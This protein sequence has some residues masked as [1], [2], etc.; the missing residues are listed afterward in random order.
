MARTTISG[1]ELRDASITNDDIAAAAAIATTKLAD[2]AAF[3]KSSGAVAMAADFNF[4]GFK[5]TNLGTPTLST[6]AAT[7]A[8][9]DAQGGGSPGG[10]DTN[11]QFNSASAFAGDANLTWNTTTD[12]LTVK[13]AVNKQALFYGAFGA[14]ASDNSGQIQIGNNASWY[15]KIGLEGVSNGAAFY[16][17][18]L[19]DTGPQHIFRGR[20]S[21][22][23]VTILTLTGNRYVGIAEATAPGAVLDSKSST[24]CQAWFRGWSTVGGAADQHG[25]IRFGNANNCAI[26]YDGTGN[27]MYLD[28]RHSDATTYI[29]FRLR[30]GGTP[31]TALKLNG[32]KSV[33]VGDAALATTA[34]DGFLYFTSCAGLPTGIP[35]SETGRT[36]IVWDSTNSK[37]Y[38]YQGGWTQI[39]G[40]SWTSISAG[41]ASTVST[42]TNADTS[43]VYKV[44]QTTAGRVSW[45]FTEQA[46]SVSTSTPVLLQVDTISASTAIPLLVKSR[47][48]EVFRVSATATQILG[49]NGSAANPTY[50]FLSNTNL[51][52]WNNS[53]TLSITA[54]GQTKVEIDNSQFKLTNVPIAISYSGSGSAPDIRDSGGQEGIFF[55]ASAVGISVGG[56]ENSRFAASVFQPSKGSADADSYQLNFRKSRGSVASPTVITTGD[57][58]ALISGFGYV[59]ATNAYVE[60]ANIVFESFGAVSDSSTGLSGLIAFQVREAGGA[61][62]KA[63]QVRGQGSR[64]LSGSAGVPSISDI[65][66]ENSGLF[67]PAAGVLGFTSNLVEAGRLS[68]SQNWIIGAGE[69][70]AVLTS[71]TLRGPNASGTDIAA[72]SLT[73]QNALGTGTGTLGK[74]ILK[75]AAAGTGTGTAQHTAVERL[76]LN[77]SVSLTSGAAAT[78]VTPTASTTKTSGGFVVYHVEATD[79]VDTISASG[80]VAYGIVN[81]AAAYT[82]VTSVIGTEAQAKSDVTDTIVNTFAFSSNALQI[83]STITGMTPTTF[84]VTYMVVSN[85]QEAIVLP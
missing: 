48:S 31:V 27:A 83:T 69:A 23:I 63:L 12:L 77:G 5:G 72:A 74:L 51:G 43:I 29:Y 19:N 15:L 65:T 39:G 44:S 28:N 60:A 11:I 66:S 26:H 32:A 1:S 36:P 24:A 62:I 9:V 78:I 59:G 37:F 53:G 13:S 84:R 73:I 21:G 30:V 41:A 68:S 18:G 71:Q 75:A 55:G 61:L 64:F 35:T 3:L 14:A 16:D 10:V 76:V 46:A 82:A 81:K 4:G 38:A 50:A 45:Q 79:G 52:I 70:S 8:Y 22:S 33:I 67:W 54:A 7:K 80:T 2:G 85:G 6:D 57:D 40:S 20:A 42:T 17:S 25:E 56:I 58:L 49:A 34:T 47:G